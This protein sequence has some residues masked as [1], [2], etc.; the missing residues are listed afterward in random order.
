MTVEIAVTTVD[1]L[2]EEPSME[3]F[4]RAILPKLLTDIHFNIYP[5]QGKDQLLA[6]LPARL[7]GYAHWIPQD[8]RIVVLVDQ[9][10]DN[11]KQ[12]KAQLEKIAL[13]AGLY[14]RTQRNDGH[15]TVI[16]RIAVEELEAWYFGDWEAVRAAYSRVPSTIPKR[17]AYRDP[18]AIKGGT[19]ESF[20]RVMKR[21]GYFKSGL[22]KIEAAK[23]IGPF[24]DP[25]RNRSPSFQ[26]F[27]DALLDKT[28]TATDTSE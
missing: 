1:F 9:D 6:R 20:E 11:C 13:D 4:L 16:N 15:F 24:F 8:H 14:T 26:A 23:T 19:W 3:A 7:K 2:I 18:D 12:L 21:A 28:M 22:R 10:S 17:S 27:R 5:F 25:N